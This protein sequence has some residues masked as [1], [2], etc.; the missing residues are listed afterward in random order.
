MANRKIDKAK[1]R[2]AGFVAYQIF[3]VLEAQRHAVA[4]MLDHQWEGLGDGL[5]PKEVKWLKAWSARMHYYAE[6][7]REMGHRLSGK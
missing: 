7:M 6:E 3:F 2:A 1:R 4:R 5:T